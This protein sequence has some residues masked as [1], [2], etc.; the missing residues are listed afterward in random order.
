MVPAAGVAPGA[1]DSELFGTLLDLERLFFLGSE[2]C[3][4]FKQLRERERFLGLLSCRRKHEV[5]KQCV[6]TGCEEATCWK[7]TIGPICHYDCKQGC[8]CE[9]GFYRDYRGKCV[10]WNKCLKQMYP[11]YTG[12]RYSWLPYTEPA[13]TGVV[14]VA[15]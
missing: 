5:Y 11:L 1:P 6:G 8:F 12:G 14:P 9:T 13:Y 3:L 7:P 10:S 2:R 4:D 15:F